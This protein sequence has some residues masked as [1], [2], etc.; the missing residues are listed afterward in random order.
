M[1]G[2]SL[3]VF[4]SSSL[5]LLYYVGA[6]PENLL[7]IF[8]SNHIVIYV[9]KTWTQIISLFLPILQEWMDV[10]ASDTVGTDT[11]NN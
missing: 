7:E 11:D 4:V 10:W 2:D 5:Y 8:M 3:C 6:L 1:S 9:E